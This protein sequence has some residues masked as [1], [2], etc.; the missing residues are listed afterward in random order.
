MKPTPILFL[1]LDGTVRLGKDELGHFVNTKEDVE[2]FP[3]VLDILKSY[4]SYGWKIVAI[5]NQGGIALGHVDDNTMNKIMAETN[6]LCANL[7]DRM[8][9]CPHHPDAKANDEETREERA[10]CFCRKP[11]IGM[12]V[13]AIISL[14]QEYAG[15]IFR[16]YNSLMVGD[17]AEDSVCASN[18]NMP[19]MWA[20]DW[21]AR[22]PL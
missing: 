3:G 12:I 15:K 8:L 13:S 17:R 4:K 7:F 20:K 11:N 10:I 9:W 19:F 16:P 21:R 5:S 1:D 14:S 22:G 2:I 18:A 6:R